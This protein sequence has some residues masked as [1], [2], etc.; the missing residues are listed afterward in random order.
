MTIQCTCTHVIFS[1]TLLSH[2]HTC[3]GINTYLLG[4]LGMNIA[5]VYGRCS[6]IYRN[7]RFEYMCD[8]GTG[9]HGDVHTVYQIIT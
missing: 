7:T 8:V 1:D 4:A 3:D 6:Y 5:C 2:T 9:A